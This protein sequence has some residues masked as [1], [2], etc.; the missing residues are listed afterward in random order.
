MMYC[1]HFQFSYAIWENLN[2][3]V[4]SEQYLGS[5]KEY[6]IYIAQEPV[7]QKKKEKRKLKHIMELRVSLAIQKTDLI[8][9]K[10]LKRPFLF[11]KK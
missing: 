4:I 2:L 5:A 11:L 6:D 3:P 8:F 7:S 1:N 9:K 10:S